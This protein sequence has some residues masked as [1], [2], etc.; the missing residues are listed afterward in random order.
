MKLTKLWPVTIVISFGVW[1]F[2][3]VKRSYILR[4]VG[5]WGMI[6]GVIFEGSLLILQVIK[7]HHRG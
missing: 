6:A 7:G 4:F 5:A 1:V 3:R 2:G